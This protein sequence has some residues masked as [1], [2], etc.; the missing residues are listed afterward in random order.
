[1]IK[2]INTTYIN[3]YIVKID[4]SDGSYSNCDFSYLLSKN[5]QLTKALVDIEYF[6]SFFLELGAICW[7][8]GLELSPQSIYKK[9]KEAGELFSDKSVA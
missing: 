3:K 4:F 9:A 7:K 6:K 2:I 8:N 1:M 5:S